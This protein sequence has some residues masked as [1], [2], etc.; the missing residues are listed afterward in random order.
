MDARSIYDRVRRPRNESWNDVRIGVGA[1]F[2]GAL[3]FLAIGSV[4]SRAG[5][6]WVVVPVSVFLGLCVGLLV[7]AI[8]DSLRPEDSFPPR[9]D[10]GRD[11]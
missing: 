9:E 4:L 1:M 11:D 5:I 6:A 3:V 8:L 10:V 7:G 2:V